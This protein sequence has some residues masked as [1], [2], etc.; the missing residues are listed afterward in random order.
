MLSPVYFNREPIRRQKSGWLILLLVAAFTV[1][2]GHMAAAREWTVV[3]IPGAGLSLA[4]PAELTPH[5]TGTDIKASTSHRRV[6]S[7]L[8]TGYGDSFISL[9]VHN[10]VY[11][12]GL[13]QIIDNFGPS[14]RGT[15]V[16]EEGGNISAY[17]FERVFEAVLERTV[18]IPGD[19]G[20]TVLEI[21]LVIPD[22]VD[23]ANQ[24]LEQLRQ[25]H[26]KEIA[27]MDAI[28]KTLRREPAFVGPRVDEFADA[29]NTEIFRSRVYHRDLTGDGRADTILV[30]SARGR[31][32]G[33]GPTTKITVLRPDDDGA[34]PKHEVI[35]ESLGKVRFID[36]TGNGV[37]DLVVS[38]TIGIHGHFLN[39]VTFSDLS[40][41]GQ[42][43]DLWKE[44]NPLGVSLSVESD[45]PVIRTGI[46]PRAETWSYADPRPW[47]LYRWRD[48]AFQYDV[49]ELPALDD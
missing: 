12:P 43:V 28:L 21:T 9:I 15:I 24:P 38:G 33:S 32:A 47:R 1:L 13:N 16:G 25:R 44:V 46:E 39:V 22:I 7:N 30:I 36:I 4:H 20:D 49:I 11:G 23:W 6:I 26:A 19:D 42:A 34:K 3:E 2:P 48:G 37:E 14:L 40:Q 10:T 31:S 18:L 8:N 17:L 45:G 29:S 27:L 35:V 41:S 5:P